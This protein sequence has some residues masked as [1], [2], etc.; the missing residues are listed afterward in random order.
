MA[1]LNPRDP[2]RWIEREQQRQQA[3]KQAKLEFMMGQD[4]AAKGR[5]PKW[6]H[7]SYILGYDE[8]CRR[9]PRFQPPLDFRGKGPGRF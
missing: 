7:G 8:A 2:F 4:D 3:Q 9:L 5:L 1:D 6:N